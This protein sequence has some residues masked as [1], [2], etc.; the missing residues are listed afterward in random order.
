MK[1]KGYCEDYKKWQL[2]N[3]EFYSLIMLNATE[4]GGESGLRKN[5]E[6][7]EEDQSQQPF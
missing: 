3:I 1:K 5:N 7:P 6:W 2:Y 4:F